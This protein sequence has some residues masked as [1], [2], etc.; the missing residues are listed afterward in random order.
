MNV[1]FLSLTKTQFEALETKAQGTFYLVDGTKLY[2]GAEYLSND[3]ELAA[4]IVRVGAIESDYLKN[5]DKTALQGQIDSINKELGALTGTDSGKSISQMIKDAVDTLD[6]DL[7]GQIDTISGD[8]ATIKGDYLKAADKTELEGKITAEQQ[9]AEGIEGGL[10][11]RLAAVEEDVNAFFKDATIS[12][13]AKDTLK[14][15]QTYIES[16]AEAAAAM[17]E[18]INGV[19]DRVKAI[20][21]DYLVEADKTE[22][23]NAISG[24]VS[25]GDFDTLS[26]TVST[27]STTVGTK[28][29]KSV[30]EGIDGRVSSVEGKLTDITSVKD[31]IA[32]AKQGAIDTAAEDATTKANSALSSAKT[33]TNEEIT[34]LSS[35]YDAKGAAN[36][37]LTDAKKYTDDEIDALSEVYDVKGAAAGA[38]TRAKSYADGLAVNYD[39]A[40]SAAAAETAAKAYADGLA[41][42]YD[43]VGSASTAESNAKSYTDAEIKKLDANVS[44]ATVESGKGV[45]VQVVETDGIV[46]SVAVSGNY[47]N[48]Y[49]A[50]GAAATA[51][52]NAVSTAAG[53]ATTKANNALKDAKAYTDAALTWE[54]VE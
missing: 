49:D 44:S 28:A 46:T 51:E 30:V 19:K 20:E 52:S 7:Q 18:S 2:L 41:K 9:R 54:V 32:T 3:A 31:A 6:R 42:N 5:A 25:Q 16:D 13:A 15:I 38:E 36:T 50:K 48:L 23:S 37:A 27:L 1:K 21:D 35:V 40:G 22:L 26:G 12:E 4:A 8:V 11:T 43:A 53:D 17:T 47:N 39:A 33:Y 34:K 29:D 10:N 24:K 45:Q 14:E